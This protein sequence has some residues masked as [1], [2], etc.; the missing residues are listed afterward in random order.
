VYIDSHLPLFLNPTWYILTL[1]ICLEVVLIIYYGFFDCL[2][3]LLLFT[4]IAI[5]LLMTL[6]FSIIE[7]TLSFSAK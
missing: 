3:I 4:Y 6:I 5:K 2:P 7:V 1:N